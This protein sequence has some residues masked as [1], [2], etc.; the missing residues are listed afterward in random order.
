MEELRR[1]EGIKKG[2][3]CVL[4]TGIKNTFGL[5]LFQISI[6]FFIQHY[7]HFSVRVLQLFVLSFAMTLAD[8]ASQLLL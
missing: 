1:S 6:A 3:N 2:P 5:Y 7:Q 8:A 4:V